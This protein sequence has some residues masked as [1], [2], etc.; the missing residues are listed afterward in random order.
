MRTVADGGGKYK[1]R[2]EVER[3]FGRMKEN[4]HVATRYDK[5]DVTYLAFVQLAFIAIALRRLRVNAP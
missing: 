2:N 1:K 3:K 5:L 4:R